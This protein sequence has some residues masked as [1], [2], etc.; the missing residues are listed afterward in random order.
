MSAETEDNSIC[1][2]ENALSL[3]L[4]AL[5]VAV[6]L[7]I[8]WLL[9][10]SVRENTAADEAVLRGAR[11]VERKE[12]RIGIEAKAKAQ[13]NSYGWRENFTNKLVHIPVEKAMQLTIAD[14]ANKDTARKVLT[15]RVAIVTPPAPANDAKAKK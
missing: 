15:K 14:Y 1:C 4:Y 8:G 12:T 11:G 6:T 7:L 5:G 9:T 13:A 3:V 10:T 2:G